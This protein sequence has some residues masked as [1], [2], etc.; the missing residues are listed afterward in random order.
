MADEQI[1]VVGVDATDDPLCASLDPA[2]AIAQR[3]RTGWAAN[4]S[5]PLVDER[6]D[7]AAG[8][9]QRGVSRS[10]PANRSSS[11]QNFAA[12]VQPVETYIVRSTKHYNVDKMEN[13]RLEGPAEARRCRLILNA[14][15]ILVAALIAGCS[16]PPSPT[17]PSP[18]PPPAP[19]I[20][21]W[22]AARAEADAKL[23]RL[24]AAEGMPGVQAAVLAGGAVVWQAARGTTPEGA[25]VTST[26]RFPLASVSKIATV[27]LLAR[28]VADRR[29]DLDAAVSTYVPSWSD[30]G[31]AITVRQLAGHLA[32]IRH[33]T[34]A[35]FGRSKTYAHLADAA[36]DIFAADPRIAAP[37]ERYA[38]SSWG[39]TLLGAVLEGAAQRSYLELLDRELVKPTGVALTA[40]P[41]ASARWPAGGLLGTAVDLVR[42]GSL[43]L[44]G[45]TYVAPGIVATMLTSQQTRTGETTGVGLGWRV[46]A[47][48][49][50]RRIAHHAGNLPNARSVVIV[51]VDLGVVVALMSNRGG[52]PDDVERAAGELAA[53]FLPSSHRD[54]SA[55]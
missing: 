52:S 28:L 21:P 29:V 1:A 8:N 13:R 32:G 39:F 4:I 54:A 18:P 50:G 23:E 53:P 19:V 20:D 14:T 16:K 11:R 31:P 6:D 42:L 26:S 55:R 3:P 44:P 38:Y 34:M 12:S 41:D 10:S 17:P 25:E 43:V 37:G 22:V 46:G 36:A 2:T 27:L 9:R 35:D 30:A 5:P 24:H 49:E 48:P 7:R 45:A 33:Y 51:Y 40:D 47:D 15:W